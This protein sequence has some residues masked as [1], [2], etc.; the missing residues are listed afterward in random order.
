MRR[1]QAFNLSE[2]ELR[3]RIL[4]PWSA[5]EAVALGDREWDPGA[6][7]IAVLE[8]RHLDPP[9]LAH[10]QGWNNALRTGQDVTRAVFARLSPSP[11]ERTSVALLVGNETARRAM[12]SLLTDLQ[13]VPVEWAA[14]RDR[15]LTEGDAGIAAAV[16]VVDGPLEEDAFDVGTAVGSLGPRALLVRLGGGSAPSQLAAADTIRIDANHPEGLAALVQRLR[17]CGCEVR[18]SPGWDAPE[19]FADL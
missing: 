7:R 9:E 10:G 19:R 8:G 5:G 13:L 17:A 3:G 1:A 14:V 4:E 18:P 2:A 16:V 15:M 12:A 11:A 6:S